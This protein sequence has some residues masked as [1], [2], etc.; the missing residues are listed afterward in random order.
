MVLKTVDERH[1][2][3]SQIENER[4]E[5]EEEAVVVVLLAMLNYEKGF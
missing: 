4:D 1:R 5:E 2:P 3:C